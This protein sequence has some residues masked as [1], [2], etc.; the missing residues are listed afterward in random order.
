LHRAATAVFDLLAA[1][2]LHKIA[3]MTEDS[4]TE[5]LKEWNR[6]AR[7]NAENAMVSSMLEAGARASKPIE[8]FATWL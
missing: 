3:L 8:A 5:P 6:L 1:T 2:N 4:M 7:E